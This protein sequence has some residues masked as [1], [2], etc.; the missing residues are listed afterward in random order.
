MNSDEIVTA[1]ADAL[2][3]D[4]AADIDAIDSR[5]CSSDRFKGVSLTILGNAVPIRTILDAVG[6]LD[7]WR[8]EQ[9]GMYGDA[10]YE[11]TEDGETEVETG[12]IVF[13]ANVEH[14]L[15][16]AESDVFV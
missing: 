3:E 9:I 1:V 5:V 13:C 7:A 16:I 12:L 4:R 11:S 8:V 14:A 6:R 15:E 10:H 2:D